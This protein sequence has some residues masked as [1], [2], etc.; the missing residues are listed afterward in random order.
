MPDP[1][2]RRYW[3]RF[4]DQDGAWRTDPRSGSPIR[5]PGEDLAALRSGLGQP[6]LSVSQVW[7]FYTCPVDDRLARLGRVSDE[8]SAEH[9]ALALFGLHQQ[10]QQIPMHRPGVGLGTALRSLRYSGK[11]SEEAV[12]SRVTTAVNATSVPALLMRLRVL[13]TQLRAIQQPVDYDLLMADIQRW[14]RP[15]SRQ[16]VRRGWGLGY[17]AWAPP[18]TTGEQPSA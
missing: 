16:R 7:P 3:N 5:P 17:H 18:K 13:I 11:F 15:E 12:D 10:A 4:V 6:A 8:Q 1:T 2:R 14:H 9:A